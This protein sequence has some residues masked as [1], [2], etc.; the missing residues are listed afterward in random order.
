[1]L[2]TTT[3]T[4]AVS[5]AIP[6][7]ALLTLDEAETLT[8]LTDLTVYQSQG[9]T[10]AAYVMFD[11]PLP[12]G[13]VM[14]VGSSLELYPKTMKRY[15]AAQRH[16]NPGYKV[17]RLTRTRLEAVRA[18]PKVTTN[19]VTVL[20]SPAS[21]TG[22]GAFLNVDAA[23]AADIARA[24]SAPLADTQANRARALA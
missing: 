23:A 15:A 7:S 10:T 17:T 22:S 11:H 21:A 24:A 13:N 5:Q 1:M 12:S 19:Y 18:T 16:D 3:T 4:L 8:G 6:P 2:A 14:S 20:V 9:T